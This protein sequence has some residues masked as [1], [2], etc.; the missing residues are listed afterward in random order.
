MKSQMLIEARRPVP[1]GHF[2]NIA[3]GPTARACLAQNRAP[4][5]LAVRG[6][7]LPGYSTRRCSPPT[8]S[9]DC[10]KHVSIAIARPFAAA[11]AATTAAERTS[12]SRRL[13]LSR[14]CSCSPFGSHSPPPVTAAAFR[15]IVLLGFGFGKTKA[16]ALF[17][18][19]H[20]S[21]PR[22]I[23]DHR[24]GIAQSLKFRQSI[25]PVAGKFPF[26]RHR[27]LACRTID[28]QLMYQ[29]SSYADSPRT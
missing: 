16:S 21:A 4:R 11:S 17:S 5:R 6:S 28:W 29:R 25:V 9:A 1:S 20:Q 15:L 13:V 7:A 27:L 8:A 18:H 19:Q 22:S 14:S 10:V 26:T 24:S 2:A 23:A 3:S 12:R